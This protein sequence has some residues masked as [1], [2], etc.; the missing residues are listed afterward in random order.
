MAALQIYLRDDEP[1]ANPAVAGRSADW[2]LREP[3]GRILSAG[4]N[5]FA[6][7]PAAD[8]VDVVVPA[9]RVLFT[10]V[11][12]PPANAAKTRQLL[13]FAIEDKLLANPETIHAVAGTREE[14]GDT[15]VAVVDKTWVNQVM[16]RLRGGLSLEGI[17][18]PSHKTVPGLLPAAVGLINMI[19]PF[20]LVSPAS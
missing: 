10:R 1:G 12:L 15:P 5:A 19:V 14:N 3:R 16:A 20:F 8:R 18:N 17:R 9:S 6:E 7:M 11:N 4:N 2:V 13:P